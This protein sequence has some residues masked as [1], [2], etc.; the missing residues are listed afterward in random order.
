MPEKTQTTTSDSTTNLALDTLKIK[1]QALIFTNTKRSAEKTAEEISL[2]IKETSKELEE[3]SNQIL[4]ALSR[5]TKQ[6]KRLANCIKKGID[7]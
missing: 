4:N 2:K 5:P 1:K 3:L 7:S 6:C